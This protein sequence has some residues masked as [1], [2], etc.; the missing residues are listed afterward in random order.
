MDKDYCE[1]TRFDTDEMIPYGYIVKVV[2]D[3]ITNDLTG[4]TFKSQ[5]YFVEI[6]DA[7]EFAQSLNIYCDTVVMKFVDGGWVQI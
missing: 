2:F 6:K 1:V 7:K 5:Q 3:S 4:E